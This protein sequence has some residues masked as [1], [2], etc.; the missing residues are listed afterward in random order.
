VVVLFC[1]RRQ[2]NGL[3]KA[4][5]RYRCLDWAIMGAGLDADALAVLAKAQLFEDYILRGKAD[6]NAV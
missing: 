4:E 1:E 6:H 2:T 5:M 3:R